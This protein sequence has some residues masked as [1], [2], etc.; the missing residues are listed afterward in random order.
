VLKEKNL[1]EENACK[2]MRFIIIPVKVKVRLS[3]CLTKHHA[4]MIYWGS[5]GIAPHTS[6]L[7]GVEWSASCPS[8]SNT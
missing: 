7:D 2:I 6:A 5:G 3:L 4:M 1:L 8:C